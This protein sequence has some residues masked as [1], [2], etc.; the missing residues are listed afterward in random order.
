MVVP[1]ISSGC[2]E[3]ETFR[4]VPQKLIT[5]QVSNISEPSVL[6]LA[7]TPPLLKNGPKQGAGLIAN[8]AYALSKI[9]QIGAKQGV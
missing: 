4:T 7:I 9:F 2:T 8:F 3:N 5:F 1:T 6:F